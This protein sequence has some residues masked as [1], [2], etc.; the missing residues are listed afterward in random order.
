MSECGSGLAY[1]SDDQRQ[2]RIKCPERR[3][4]IDS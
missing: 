2:I 4:E 1:D 3:Q